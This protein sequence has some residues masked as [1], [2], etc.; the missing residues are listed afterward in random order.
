MQFLNFLIPQTRRQSQD[1]TLLDSRLLVEH[2]SRILSVPVQ[3]TLDVGDGHSPLV[4][5]AGTFWRFKLC[6]LR[7]STFEDG[8]S[9]RILGIQGNCLLIELEECDA[10]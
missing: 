1:Q 2:S 4:K 5:F 10:N 9:V 8:Q 6:G 7:P 3:A